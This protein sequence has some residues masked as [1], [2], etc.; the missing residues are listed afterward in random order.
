[1]STATA[2]ALVNAFAE[3][4][5]ASAFPRLGKPRS[6]VAASLRSRVLAPEK[7]RQGTSSLCGPAAFLY[8]LA[9]KEPAAYAAYVIDLYEKG[10]AAIG[11]LKV[12]PGADTRNSSG[13]GVDAVDWVALSSLRDSENLLLDYQSPD[14]QLAGIT[15]PGTLA[16]WFRRC[17]HFAEIKNDTNLVLDKGLSTLLKAHQQHA[18]GG[19]ACLLVG[20]TVLDDLPSGGGLIPDHWVVLASN[21]S[22]DGK[23]AGP[24]LARGAAIDGE[25][26]LSSKNL[27]FDVFSWGSILS[28][29]M[30]VSLFLDYFYGFIGTK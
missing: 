14:N 8:V 10:T 19:R 6:E 15:A 4:T 22:I 29:N 7:I 25:K 21:V 16:S 5:G 2:L 27:S 12:A 11:K 20:A 28:V 30:K 1:M 3:G 9:S 24:L 26:A 18:A 13:A 17:G 23:P